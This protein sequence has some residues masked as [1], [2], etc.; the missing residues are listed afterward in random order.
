MDGRSGPL[1]R[2]HEVTIFTT[3][4]GLSDWERLGY[5]DREVA[6]YQRWARRLGRVTF[7]TYGDTQ[8]E[9]AYAARIS[10]IQVAAAPKARPGLLADVRAVVRQRRLLRSCDLVKT[11][12][13]RG[14]L[15]GVAAKWIWGRPL[16]VR[17]GF[18]PTLFDRWEGRTS[19]ATVFR[20]CV[21][22]LALRAADAVVVTTEEDKGY[23]CRRHGLRP[24]KVAVIGNA[25]DVERFRPMAEVPKEPGTV[26]FVGR[27]SKE[28]NLGSLI[29]ALQGTALELVAYG[30]GGLGAEL[31]R[32]AAAC[33]VRVR[34]C[35][36][37]PNSRLPEA[38]NRAAVVALPSL[39][40]GHP[41]VLLEAMACGSCVVTTPVPGIRSIASDGANAVVCRGTR[42]EDLR[43]GLERALGD[44]DL[45]RRVGRAARAY[46]AEHYAVDVLMEREA[47]LLEALLRRART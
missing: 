46:V 39:H 31:A 45:A 13:V 35:G 15:V 36:H 34:W 19:A 4:V 29:E 38:Y 25:I 33:G 28:K 12:Q 20:A 18:V 5:L 9:S 42:P 30:S 11:K 3:N 1:S 14:G 41:K 16:V 24:E 47:R 27:F 7:L 22:R 40:E 2:I 21:E 43:A 26:C 17:C 23:V 37:V 8:Q 32:Q 44:A 10:P 6:I